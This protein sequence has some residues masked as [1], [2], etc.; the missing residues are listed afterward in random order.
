MVVCRSS[1]AHPISSQRNTANLWEN[2]TGVITLGKYRGYIYPK[3]VSSYDSGCWH[4]ID[5]L[6]NCR[7]D[8]GIAEGHGREPS[9]R[10]CLGPVG[11][12]SRK[13]ETLPVG[14]LDLATLLGWACAIDINQ[15]MPSCLKSW[16]IPP[17]Q[18]WQGY[19]KEYCLVEEVRGSFSYGLQL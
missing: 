14:I 18:V 17:C 13:P 3:N 12:R 6:C 1:S 16:R 19:S 8:P 5:L 11:A 10:Q 4:E 7:N 9:P 2:R 15:A